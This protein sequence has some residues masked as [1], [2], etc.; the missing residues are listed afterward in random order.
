MMVQILWALL[1]ASVGK[2]ALA[3]R[4]NAW[5]LEFG[6]EAPCDRVTVKSIRLPNSM[7]GVS[8]NYLSAENKKA[9]LKL[10]T[11]NLL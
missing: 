9:F 11:S 4:K 1:D 7:C 6:A 3:T 8:V 10:T 5:K 2:P